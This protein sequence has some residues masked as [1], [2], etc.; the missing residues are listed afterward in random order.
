MDSMSSDNQR[1]ETQVLIA[2]L[3]KTILLVQEAKPAVK[4]LADE[5]KEKC[6]DFV[7]P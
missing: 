4:L 6:P 1:L 5:A 7:E 3:E 2:K